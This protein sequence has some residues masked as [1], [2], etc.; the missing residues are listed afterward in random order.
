MQFL[1]KKTM[2]IVRMINDLVVTKQSK[3]SHSN[4]MSTGS[5]QSSRCVTLW[6]R[7]CFLSR[8]MMT[9]GGIGVDLSDV[10]SVKKKQ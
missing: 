4:K 10:V 2:S 9:S 5:W 6:G 8:L 1:L 3:F 7:S